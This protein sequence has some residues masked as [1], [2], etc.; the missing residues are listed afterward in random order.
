LLCEVLRILKPGGRAVLTT[1]NSDSLGHQKFR[2]CWFG[3][4]PPRHLQVFSVTTLQELA[5][6]A[7]FKVSRAFSTAANADIFIGASFSIQSARGRTGEPHPPPNLLRTVKCVWW[8]YREHVG[9]GSRPNG[10]EEVV[11][12]AAK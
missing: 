10:G 2:E 1:P 5:R 3:L 6:R 4:D 11:V 7:G 9:L 8:Q 12:A